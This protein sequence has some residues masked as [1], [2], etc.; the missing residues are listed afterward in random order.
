MRREVDAACRLPLCRLSIF[1]IELFLETVTAWAGGGAAQAK[2]LATRSGGG[3]LLHTALA[4]STTGVRGDGAARGT[5]VLQNVERR[6][7]G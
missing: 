5:S 1:P 3:V 6:G 4:K 7:L 2:P